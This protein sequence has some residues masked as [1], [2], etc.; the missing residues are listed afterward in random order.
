MG[1]VGSW[2]QSMI[3]ANHRRALLCCML[4]DCILWERLP[5]GSNQCT[6]RIIENSTVV[7]V[8]FLLARFS[9]RRLSV[10]I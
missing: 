7:S 1:V 6:H 4:R 10:Q 5:C 9:M 8:F 3:S 2:A